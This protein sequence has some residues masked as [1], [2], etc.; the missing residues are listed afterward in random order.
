MY[1]LAVVISSFFSIFFALL[2]LSQ[3]VFTVESM[4]ILNIDLSSV[5]SVITE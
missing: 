2:L 1:H 3:R 5:N 4:N